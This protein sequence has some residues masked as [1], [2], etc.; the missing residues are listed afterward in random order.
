MRYFPLDEGHWAMSLGV[1]PL[2]GQSLVEPDAGQVALKNQLLDRDLGFHYQALPGTEA[3]QAEVGPILG[4]SGGLLEVS[5]QVAEDL[6]LLREEPDWPLVAGVLCFPNDWCLANKLG[7]PLLEVHGPV[8]GFLEAVGAGT[9]KL[10]D[11]LKPERPVWRANWAVKVT[12]RLDLPPLVNAAFEPVKCEVTAGNAGERCYFRVERQ[13]LSRLPL[14]GG[15]L[16]TVRTYVAPLAEL[17]LR[18]REL[19]TRALRTMPAAM[20]SYKGIEPFAG[21]LLEYLARSVSC[22]VT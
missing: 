9:L 2:L 22:G 14:S 21:P 4:L 7:L 6:L 5:R 8:P 19:L 16:F 13:T 18:E 12:D 17:D 20:L 10:L 3:M 1:R 15:I 11:K